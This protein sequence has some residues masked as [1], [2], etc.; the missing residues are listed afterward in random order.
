MGQRRSFLLMRLY[1]RTAHAATRLRELLLRGRRRATTEVA[2]HDIDSPQG[3]G[4][5][6]EEDLRRAGISPGMTSLP[7]TIGPR[8]VAYRRG[9][10]PPR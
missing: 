9:L 7:G 3:W 5:L 1:A 2:A 10:K 8:A 4:G 6:T